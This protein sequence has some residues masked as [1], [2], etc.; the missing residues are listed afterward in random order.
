MSTSALSR[1]EKITIPPQ[2]PFYGGVTG[3]FEFMQEEIGVFSHLPCSEEDEKIYFMLRPDDSKRY[4]ELLAMQEEA[5]LQDLDQNP[6]PDIDLNP[7]VIM[8]AEKVPL[9]IP[10]LEED[11]LV[12]Y[13][14]TWY[15]KDTDDPIGESVLLDLTT[16]D[17]VRR[18]L[19]L[20][21]EEDF[22]GCYKINNDRLE[23]IKAVS[24]GVNVRLDLY[25][26]YVEA[27]DA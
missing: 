3:I 25:D 5:F 1:G 21:P 24:V 13:M 19:G 16:E 22:V 8:C 10:T 15:T 23:W 4:Q 7:M 2:H 17:E 18:G 12:T 14:L 6:L 11:F 20:D 9:P 27:F 26:Y